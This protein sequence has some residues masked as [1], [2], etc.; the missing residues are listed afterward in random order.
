DQKTDSPVEILHVVLLWSAKY[1]RQD[2]VSCQD[3]EG[4]DIPKARINS[5]DTAGIGLTKSPGNTLVQ[6]AGSLTGRDFR[7]IPQLAPASLYRLI[8][9][10]VCEVSLALRLC[11]F[12]HLAFQPEIIDLIKY[13][14]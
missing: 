13:L 10:E 4:K 6:Y 14:V 11:H 8:P 2:T 7:L 12:V 1:F 3:L 5:F 9:E